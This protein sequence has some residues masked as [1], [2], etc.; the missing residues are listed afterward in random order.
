MFTAKDALQRSS[1]S[2]TPV[3]VSAPLDAKMVICKMQRR[4]EE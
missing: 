1:K 3:C 4:N 2:H